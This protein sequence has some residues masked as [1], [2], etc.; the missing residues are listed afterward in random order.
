VKTRQQAV[1]YFF[2][3]YRIEQTMHIL[4]DPRIRREFLHVIRVGGEVGLDFA[5]LCVVQAMIHVGLQIRF[6]DG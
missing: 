6:S 1:G 5:T 3:Q 2:I 4:V